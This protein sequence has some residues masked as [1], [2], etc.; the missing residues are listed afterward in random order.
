MRIIKYLITL[1][2]LWS[3]IGNAAWFERAYNAKADPKEDFAQA[4]EQARQENK[5]VLITFGANWCKD[6]RILDKHLKKAPLKSVIEKEFVIVK[7][8]IGYWDRNMDFA[9]WFGDPTREGI[10]SI[11]IVGSDKQLY[12]ATTGGELATVRK[13]SSEALRDWFAYLLDSLEPTAAN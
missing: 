10:P 6:C 11:A 9:G 2:L 12:Y 3:Q 8:D 5:K 4:L 7:A 13:Q 1:T